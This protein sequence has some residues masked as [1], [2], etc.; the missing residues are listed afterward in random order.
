MSIRVI[1]E[2]D[3]D[4]VS[5]SA[6]NLVR[7]RAGSAIASGKPE[8]VLGLATGNSPTGMYKHLARSINNGELDP[9]RLRSF[10]LDE[11]VGLP[12]ANAQDRTIHP[13]SYSYFMIQEFFG[14]LK[15]KFL[16][17]RVPPGTLIDQH[18]LVSELHAHPG[19]W[20]E[21]GSGKGRAI[22]ISD[23][24]DGYLAWVRDSVLGLYDQEISKVG[25]IDLQVIGVGGKGHVAFHE[26]G[27]DFE[28]NRMLLVKLDDNT[29]ENAVKDGHFDSIDDCPLYAVS[30]GAE[31]VFEAKTV[32][33][34]ADGSRKVEPISRAILGEV[35]PAVPLS[36]CQ[37]F[38]EHGGELICFIDKAAGRGLLENRALLESKGVVLVDRSEGMAEISAADICFRRDPVSGRL[39]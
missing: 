23:A 13:E 9:S 1:V 16:S 33:L 18:I 37:T 20:K 10:N 19:D 30:M 15:R 7:E 3:F 36:Y 22:V 24:A 32:V 11:Y 35:S 12:G 27:I 29:V 28:G 2:R 39:I 26:A 38:S 8:F 31:L 25:G 34:L 17:S 21:V 14:L 4:A 6:A 5:E